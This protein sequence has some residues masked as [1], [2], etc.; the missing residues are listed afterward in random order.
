[1]DDDKEGRVLNA[2]GLAALETA[3]HYIEQQKQATPNASVLLKIYHD[4]A[5][6][7]NFSSKLAIKLSGI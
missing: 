6:Y 4:F 7:K 3:L 1:M 5:A 2:E